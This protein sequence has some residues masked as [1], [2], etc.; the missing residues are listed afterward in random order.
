MVRRNDHHTDTT[1]EGWTRCYLWEGPVS[2]GVKHGFMEEAV[3]QT[4]GEG[5]SSLDGN[6]PNLGPKSCHCGKGG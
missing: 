5:I 4:D 1:G 2:P 6:F 3:L